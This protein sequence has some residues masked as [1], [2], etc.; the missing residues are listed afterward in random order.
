MTIIKEKVFVRD[1]LLALNEDVLGAQ[2]EKLNVKFSL[3]PHTEV[4]RTFSM[5]RR[6]KAENEL[7]LPISLRTGVAISVKNGKAADAMTVEEWQE[8]Y[9]SLKR[10]LY[11]TYPELFNRLFPGE[12][13]SVI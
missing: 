13:A 3:A 4:G 11:V 5:V 10:H 2:L 9:N 7:G 8:F 1:E 12:D 6:M